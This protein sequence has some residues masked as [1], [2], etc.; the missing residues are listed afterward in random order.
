MKVPRVFSS[1]CV[2]VVV[3]LLLFALTPAVTATG[4]ESP[5]PRTHTVTNSGPWAIET[6]VPS[7]D[8]PSGPGSARGRPVSLVLDTADT[9]HIAYYQPATGEIR[10]LTVADGIWI[11]ERAAP[12]KGTYS[13]SIAVNAAGEPSISYGDDLHSGNLMYAERRGKAWSV[14]RVD[15]GSFAGIPD[16]PLGNAGQYSSLAL[17]AEGDPHIAYDDGHEFTN[18]KYAVRKG[19]IWETGI[20]DRGINGVLAGNTGFDPWLKLS[21]AG[22]PA[23][24]YRDG[25]YFGSLMYAE[26]EGDSWKITKVDKGWD[27][28]NETLQDTFGDTGW[29]SSLALDSGGNPVIAYYDRKKDSLM[30]AQRIQ[31]RKEFVHWA[32]G[33]PAPTAAHDAGEFVSLAIDNN[34]DRHMSYY[35]AT[36]KALM[37]YRFDGRSVR[38]ICVDTG[39]AG[40]YASL[41][42]TSL[43]KPR[44]VYYH[45]ED[46]AL[47]LASWTR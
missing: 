2:A 7:W 47:R 4:T 22:N 13:V 3:M 18:L 17:D 33:M 23:V 15:R 11:D 35:D 6:I 16:S 40:R 32:T 25:S 20:I 26:M 46:H 14:S 21:P 24:S 37:Y 10:Y 5:G 8:D 38:F 19:G 45:A 29:F 44:I 34:N 39:N 12:T 43:G 41:A 30:H 28:D 36:S 42:L 31:P 9:P 27:W 1:V